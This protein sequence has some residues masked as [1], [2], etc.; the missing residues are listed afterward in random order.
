M[1]GVSRYTTCYA[2]NPGEFLLIWDASCC[3]ISGTFH[4]VCSYWKLV[5]CL[6]MFAAAVYRTI[7]SN[8][9]MYF[10]VD[11]SGQSFWSN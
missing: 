3:S 5:I 1:S 7:P 2:K 4:E 11:Y 10:C 6:D 9:E 8:Q